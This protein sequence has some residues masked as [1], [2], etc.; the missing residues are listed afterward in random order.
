MP[1]RQFFAS[2]RWRMLQTIAVTAA[3]ASLLSA[4]G[5]HPRP[6]T[7]ASP[8]QK[9]EFPEIQW[10]GTLRLPGKWLDD[11]PV[12]GLSDIGWDQD[13][14]LLYAVSDRGWLHRLRLAFR[15]GELVGAKALNTYTLRDETDVSLRGALSDAEGLQ[16][17]RANNDRRGDSRLVISFEQQPRV[18]H[19]LPSGLAVS[20][21]F[22]PMGARG[23]APNNGMEALTLHPQYGMLAGLEATPEGMS[24][25]MTRIFSLDD[26]HEWSYPL[27]SDTGSSLTAMEMLP[28]GDMLMLERAFSPP[29]PLVISLRR[30][31]LGEPGTQAEVRTLARLSSGD[32]WS[33]DNFEGL[34]HLEGNR[35]LMISDDNFSSFQTTLLSCFAVIEPEAF[36]AESAPE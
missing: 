15:H 26:K 27:A 2:R 19:F 14:S 22:T 25:G 18:E 20:E 1:A 9:S 7:L 10:C 13:E 23:A 24:E 3:L 31:H 11:T 29:F 12:G 28:D 34:T 17:L 32:G 36:T 33:L 6:Y 4:C 30:A 5:V 35:F 21:P 16:L 8:E